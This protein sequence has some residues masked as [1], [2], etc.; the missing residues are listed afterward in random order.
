MTHFS[1]RDGFYL[2]DGEWMA[3]D[4]F[5]DAERDCFAGYD[6]DT[7][8]PSHLPRLERE[9]EITLRFPE[10]EIADIRQFA[11]L[12][13]AADEY[14]RMT[15][16]HLNI[17]GA[18]G[19][20][21]GAIAFGVRLHRKP[22]AQGSDGRRGKDFIE[23]K[24]IGP[25]SQSTTRRFKLSGNFS[26]AL[27]VRVGNFGSHEHLARL[28]ITGRLVARRDLTTERTG[29]A[30]LSWSRACEIGAAPAS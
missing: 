4:D 7:S 23:I 11:R 18:I 20:L 9:A 17:Y 21:Y 2:G 6:P 1:E 28:P 30:G 29:C 10:A 27:L 26:H 25:R 15:G 16:K 12:A 22:D 8:G 19:E 5:G 24:T 3:W 14:H 13:L